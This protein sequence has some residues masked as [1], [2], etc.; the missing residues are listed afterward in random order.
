MSFN[1][2]LKNIHLKLSFYFYQILVKKCIFTRMHK[3]LEYFWKYNLPRWSILVIDLLICAFSLT[4]A[5]FLRFNFKSIPTQE[6][7]L[8]PIA[9]AI[10]IALRAL[11]FYY[12]KIYKGVV[13]YT[14]A[15]DATRIF[16][17]VLLGSF[18][19]LVFNILCRQIFLGHY[20]LPQSVVI[21]DALVTIFIMISSRLAIKAIYFEN[22]NPEREKTHVIIYGAGESAIITKRTLDRDVAI[23]YKVIGFIDDD[24]KKQGRSLE[25]IF[26][27]PHNKL[28]SLITENK[29]EAVILSI[30]QLSVIKK[31]E[32]TDECLKLGVRVLNVPPVAKW[33]N[34]E[35]SFNQIKNINI[36]ELLERD[37]IQLDTTLINTQLNH[38]VVLITGA[39]GSIGSEL[40]RQCAKFNPSL[41]ILLDQAESPLHDIDLEFA[42]KAIVSK[43]E[44]VIADV[45]NKERMQN[46]FTSFKPQVVFH[47]AA[48]KHV[49]MMENN[50]SE[51]ILTNILGTKVVADLAVENQVEKFVMVSTDKA[52][53]PTNVM[54]ASKR[55]AEIYIQSLG[56]K[57][58]TT[59]LNQESDT[60]RTSVT[61]YKINTKFI[62]TRFGNV[63]G[64]N[65]SVIPRFKK[66]IEQGGPITITHPDI[67]R[68]FMT[69]PEACQLVLEAGC[70][71]S[72]GEIF[73]FDMGKSIKIVDLARKMI[74]LSGLKEDTDIKIVYTGLRPGEKLYEELLASNENTLPT[75]H[76]Q[77]LIGKV[78]EYSFNDVT[79]F[80]DE[81]ILLFNTQDNTLIVSK[82]KE[83]VPEYVSNNSVFETLD[84]N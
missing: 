28:V 45:R 18:V 17:I 25:G 84:K 37:S 74:K 15:K 35:L 48:Y 13:R 36:E 68:F 52:V 65:G 40:A 57:S 6:L 21:I 79:R 70:M 41:L 60:S 27:Y 39:A 81:L 20:I 51:S 80:I 24:E 63:L 64:S 3:I 32:I 44:V 7:S 5:F 83:I 11:T 43:Y 58:A 61:D 22:K 10:V 2:H 42:E 75:H 62:T 29:V 30:Q 34:G 77:I 69:I 23:R 66:Q 8:M 49:P 59:I 67:T 76:K 54:G 38:K 73:V 56:N 47:A 55:I 50:P 4:L 46:V 19:L 16:A 26:I 31:N 53:N 72:G 1:L 12:F 33:I 9:Y 78:R 14:G 71:G 82:M